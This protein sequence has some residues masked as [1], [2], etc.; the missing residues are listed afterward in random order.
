MRPFARLSAAVFV[1]FALAMTAVGSP[2]QDSADAPAVRSARPVHQPD[3]EAVALR[4]Q[5]I[6]RLVASDN[7]GAEQLIQAAIRIDDSYGSAHRTLS[8]VLMNL[9]RY[10]EALAACK[11]ALRCD[12]TD[13]GALYNLILIRRDALVDLHQALY[14]CDMLV[15]VNSDAAESYTMRGAVYVRLGEIGL[16]LQDLDEAIVRDPGDPFAHW[17]RGYCLAQLG[18]IEES[19]AAYERTR[20][21]VPDDPEAWANTGLTKNLLKRFDEARIDLVHALE[22]DPDC[23]EALHGLASVSVH[24]GDRTRALALL[25]D[26]LRLEPEDAYIRAVRAALLFDSGDLSQALADVDRGLEAAPDHAIALFV[27]ARV[28]GARGET[29]RADADLARAREI[30]PGVTWPIEEE[31]P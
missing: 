20:E 17:N 24:Q 29:E 30:D 11:A 22:L 9:G 5:A 10:E 31:S 27:R 28:L 23:V 26:A 6:A 4:E 12:P 8:A 19:L 18:R 14:A 2:A 3:P 21:L 7:E 13:A 1:M 16:A 25:G 15:R